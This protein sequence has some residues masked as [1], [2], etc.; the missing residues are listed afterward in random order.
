MGNK[1]IMK[2]MIK[3]GD[4]KWKDGLDTKITFKENK[5][6]QFKIKFQKPNIIER[7]LIRL[8]IIKDKRHDGKKTSWYELDEMGV[9]GSPDVLAR[10]GVNK[11]YIAGCDPFKAEE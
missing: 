8:K 11:E 1:L 4:F 7:I 5:S 9:M 6:G 2:R 10:W 3:N